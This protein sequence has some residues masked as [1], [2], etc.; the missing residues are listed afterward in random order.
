MTRTVLSSVRLLDFGCGTG[1]TTVA[2]SGG[3]LGDLGRPGQVLGVDI[4]EDMIAHCRE[5]HQSPNTTF[6]QLDVSRGQS[7]TSSNLS[8][9]SLVTSFSCLHWV[10][11]QPAAVG[12]FNK[13]LKTGG[14]FLFVIAGTQ[15]VQNNPQRRV[16][17]EMKSEESW[18]DLLKDSR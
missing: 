5:H 1:E 10:P 18:R 9:F 12:L 16:F 6:Q 7:F 15:N 3:V 8:S 11:D 14:K 2:M 13:V 4:S 17:E